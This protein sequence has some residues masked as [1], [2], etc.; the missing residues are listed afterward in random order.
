MQKGVFW[1]KFREK[2]SKVWGKKH[3]LRWRLMGLVVIALIPV[4][5]A[6]VVIATE[7]RRQAIATA[8][9]NSLFLA[10]LAAT[11]QQRLIDGARDILVTLSQVPAI[12][13]NDRAACLFFL[14]N[15]LMHYPLYAN[16]GAADRNGNVFCMTLP[17][18]FPLNISDK[19]FFQ[20]S[21]DTGDFAV[22]DYQIN[23]IN[24][25]AMITLAYPILK[26]NEIP[27][28]VVFAEL[29]LRWLEQFILVASLPKGSEFRVIDQMGK[30]LAIYPR[31]DEWIGRSIP[32]TELIPIIMKNQEGLIEARDQARVRRLYAFTP[33]L[34]AKSDSYFIVISIPAQEILAK[35]TQNL[36]LTLIALIT[37]A[38]LALIV[39][40]F[41]SDYLILRQVNELVGATRMI[42]QGNLSVRALDLHQG[43]ELSELARAFNEMANTLEV[44]Q[45]EQLSSQE[46]IKRQ[47]DIAETLARI[48]ARLNANLELQGVFEAVCDE[49]L[50][51]LRVPMVG[52]LLVEEGETKFTPYFRSHDDQDNDSLFKSLPFVEI[53]KSVDKDK[54]LI[55]ELKSLTLAEKHAFSWGRTLIVIAMQHE[56]KLIG[57]LLVFVGERQTIEKDELTLLEGIADEAALAIT[58]AKLYQALKNE[59]QARARLLSNI[60]TAQE[61]ERRRIARELHDE[62]SQTL[63]ALLVGFDTLKMAY[64]LNPERVERHL[65]DLKRITEELLT[66]IHRL[67]ANL[68]PALLDDLGLTAA[69]TWY[70]DMRLTPLGIEFDFDCDGLY[71][72]YP[73]ALET[74]LFRIV[75][76]A[77]TNVIR[78]SRATMVQIKL[79]QSDSVVTLEIY[80]NGIGFDAQILQNPQ[81]DH[82]L[83]LLGMQERATL[84][85]GQ[86]EIK[87]APGE[88]T[89]IR[90]VI[91]LSQIKVSHEEN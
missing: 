58:N 42:S 29:D 71:E 16:F 61:E 27:L 79:T 24:S 77:I 41:G 5:I 4:V 1:C 86:L 76:E 75:Q 17:Q 2:L 44:R 48:A 32:E 91:P 88:G 30:V 39:A 13:N 40:W 23:P 66:N 31:R 69:I 80:D 49:V 54:P 19:T 6:L 62:T 7:Q 65:Q 33:L 87:T 68:R 15:V 90:I 14:R 57:Y 38:M 10:K 18:K 37:G 85:G 70:G 56:D 64:Q 81:N 67:I 72:R 63:T 43:G 73:P 53:V 78:H 47:K 46:Q 21:L 50:I 28:G 45:R 89:L 82:G 8:H 11:N 35:P 83:G 12:Q 20:Q 36:L 59:E 74:A 51:A 25:Q 22:S 34:S 84:L 60:M 55:L 3:S 52:I 9:Q 26:D